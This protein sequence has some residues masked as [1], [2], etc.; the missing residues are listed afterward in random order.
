MYLIVEGMP[1]TGKTTIAKELAK[2]LNAT[3]IKSIFSNTEYGTLIRSVLNSGKNKEVEYMYLMDL[4]VDELRVYK[5]LESTDVV[6]DKA[7]TSSIAHLRAHG[8]ENKDEEVVEVIKTGYDKLAEF[9]IEP[10]AVIYIGTN[11]KKIKEHLFNKRDLSEWDNVLT[12][13]LLKHDTQRNEL[14]KELNS[15]YGE[16]L[17]C[18]ECFSGSVDEMCNRIIS[19]LKEKMYV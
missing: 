16:K 10:D 15:K 11:R 4:L 14:E 1:G 7:Y 5:E 8:Y 3:Y 9:S 19:V 2:R 17:I 6:R 12:N 13:D 18:I